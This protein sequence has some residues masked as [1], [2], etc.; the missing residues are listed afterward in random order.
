MRPLSRYEPV[1]ERRHIVF[2]TNI[3]ESKRVHEEHI[4]KTSEKYFDRFGMHDHKK[5]LNELSELRTYFV[6]AS[7]NKHC[8]PHPSLKEISTKVKQKGNSFKE[9]LLTLFS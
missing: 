4:A 8:V 2:D 5:E 9:F 6:S 1:N 7:C 3:I